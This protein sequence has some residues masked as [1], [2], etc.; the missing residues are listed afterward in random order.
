MVVRSS[1]SKHGRRPR[2]RSNNDNEK[3]NRG[4]G[5][6]DRKYILLGLM[7][8]SII[9]YNQLEASHVNS[10]FQQPSQS[11]SY[12]GGEPTTATMAT[13]TT[14]TKESGTGHSPFS[15]VACKSNPYLNSMDQPIEG[16]MEGM[17]NWLD[18]VHVHGAEA[19]KK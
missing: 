18:N 11:W 2:G 4:N 17:K 10:L 9:L 6:I 7:T 13:V 16:V 1:P 5:S 8:L 15:P 14:T 12:F 3:S 19:A